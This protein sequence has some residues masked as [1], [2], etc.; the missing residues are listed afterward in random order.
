[1]LETHRNHPQ[2][3]RTARREHTHPALVDA[4]SSDATGGAL[5]ASQSCTTPCPTP[6]HGT[7]TCGGNTCDVSCDPG[8]EQVGATCTAIHHRIAAGD[9]FACALH[10]DGTVA[11]WGDSS[12]VQATPTGTFM[13]LAAGQG[14][15]CGLSVAGN[16][17]CW[18]KASMVTANA[19]TGGG[20]RA[21]GVS[22]SAACALGGDGAIACWGSNLSNRAT[23][24]A[25]VFAHLT[26]GWFGGCATDLA[27]AVRCWGTNAPPVPAGVKA[28]ALAANVSSVA[29]ITTSGTLASWG[30]F[31]Q[32][33]GAPPAGSFDRV[34]VGRESGCA[35]VGTS[36][37]CWGLNNRGQGVPP[38]ASFRELASGFEFACGI[39]VDGALACWGLNDG[40]QASPPTGSF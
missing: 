24:P 29:A 12:V 4:A 5:D 18:G 10:A 23:P 14:E 1:M 36:P 21:I 16:V 8:Y 32:G 22:S 28:R 38:T 35:V 13:D 6:D 40:G 3:R 33:V 27:G 7:A 9:G 37:T 31:G 34:T 26:M 19:P 2:Q 15:M 25:G 17:R 11:C 30:P 39:R 20:Y